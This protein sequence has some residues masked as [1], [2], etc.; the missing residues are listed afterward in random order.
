VAQGALAVECRN[1][2]VETGD[3]L[4]AIEDRD[5]R[6]AVD[7]ERAFLAEL[8]GDCDLPAGAHAVSA[9]RLRLDGLLASLDGRIVLRHRAEGADPDALG[10]EVARHL[11]DNAG[12]QRLLDN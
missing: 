8:G 6:R 5:S 4:A 11:L 2:D 1:D 7:A 9:D 12:G 10:R 3:A